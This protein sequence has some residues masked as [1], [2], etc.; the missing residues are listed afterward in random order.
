MSDMKTSEFLIKGEVKVGRMIG[1]DTTL[2]LEMQEMNV[3]STIGRVL[4]KYN[5]SHQICGHFASSDIEKSLSVCMASSGANQT[6]PLN[7]QSS[8]A[9]PSDSEDLG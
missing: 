2:K 7:D 5:C 6:L 3:H 9:V 1:A 4:S 8:I